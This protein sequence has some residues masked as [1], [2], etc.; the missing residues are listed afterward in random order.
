MISAKRAHRSNFECSDEGEYVVIRPRPDAQ[1]EL[2]A[3][4]C[5]GCGGFG[6]LVNGLDGVL[7]CCN[8]VLGCC[9]Y[10][11]GQ[12]CNDFGTGAHGLLG[13][14]FGGAAPLALAAG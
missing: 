1:R 9:G 12:C 13:L 6:Q 11:A 8:S 14:G 2:E 7:G 10:G 5:C 4:K 3:A